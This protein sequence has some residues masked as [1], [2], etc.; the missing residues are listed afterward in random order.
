MPHPASLSQAGDHGRN[1]ARHAGLEGLFGQFVGELR[2]ATRSDAFANGVSAFGGLLQGG[3][4]FVSSLYHSA[5]S[6]A[7]GWID[8]A[9][10][11]YFGQDNWQNF[12]SRVK[13]L[14]D[15][16]LIP[17]FLTVG[18]LV[19]M[20]VPGDAEFMIGRALLRAPRWLRNFLG[21][22]IMGYE[23]GWELSAS[24]K[25]G[26][27]IARPPGKEWPSKRWMPKGKEGPYTKWQDQWGRYLDPEGNPHLRDSP[28]VHPPGY[29]KDNPPN[30]PWQ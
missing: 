12:K 10:G 2:D 5:A 20:L 4:D 27:L 18:S 6:T 25:G 1:I 30:W 9:G 7:Q 22:I 13:G 29:R 19:M 3:W 26:G 17:G 15:Y 8:T 28:E 11:Y 14:W 24:S 21:P 23:E 16:E